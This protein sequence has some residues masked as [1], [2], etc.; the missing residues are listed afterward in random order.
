MV[1]TVLQM[2]IDDLLWGLVLVGVTVAYAMT[3]IGV[4]AAKRHDVSSHRKWMTI[5]C[6]LVGIW[7][8]AY[9]GKQLIFGRDH[10]GGS[11]EDYWLLYVPL[12]IVQYELGDDHNWSGWDE[13]GGW[14]ASPAAWHWCG[15]YGGRRDNASQ[16]WA[17][18]AA[19][20]WWNIIHSLFCL[21]DALLLV[22]R[23]MSEVNSQELG[24]R[25][26]QKTAEGFSPYSFF[27][28]PGSSLFTPYFLH[29]H[30]TYL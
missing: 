14:F 4:Q 30:R 5:A 22:S 12:L 29:L 25:G 15:G 9:V 11:T 24:V 18:H 13:Y 3:L 17:S 8:V 27:I 6:S 16:T 19:D 20:F 7:L 1:L 21:L 26:R 2:G 10:F 28:S 23:N